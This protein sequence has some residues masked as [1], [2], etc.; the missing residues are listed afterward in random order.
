MPR[1]RHT[2]T[3]RSAFGQDN[4]FHRARN[5]TI[6]LSPPPLDTPCPRICLWSSRSHQIPGRPFGLE[7]AKST[8]RSGC[9]SVSVEDDGEREPFS[10]REVRLNLCE[11]GR[12]AHDRLRHSGSSSLPVDVA[13]CPSPRRARY[14]TPLHSS[15]GHLLHSRCYLTLP[16]RV[17]PLLRLMSVLLLPH[18]L[19]QH[20]LGTQDKDQRNQSNTRPQQDQAQAAD[21][22][23][24]ERPPPAPSEL[25]GQRIP[26]GQ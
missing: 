14:T 2:R 8:L 12:H 4:L 10:F 15:R 18:C 3:S 25:V 23:V 24:R 21:T 11:R 1:G 19:Q 13:D 6:Q 5:T 20:R 9:A 17:T 22:A 16:L 7:R 26:P